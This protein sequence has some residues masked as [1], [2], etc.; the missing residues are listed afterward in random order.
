[1]PAIELTFFFFF[2]L[3]G[4]LVFQYQ[5]KPV[6]APRCGDCGETLAGVSDKWND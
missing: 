4:K 1:M 6:K 2:L 5:K 3:G